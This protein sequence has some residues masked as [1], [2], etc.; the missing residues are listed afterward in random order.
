MGF[1]AAMNDTFSIGEAAKRLGKAV[2]TLQRWDRDGVLKAIKTPT[3]RRVYTLQMLRASMGLADEQQC[4]TAIAYCRV[5]SQ[6]QRPDLKNQRRVVEDF[7]VTKGLANVEFLEEVGGGLNFKRPIFLR[8]IDR[9]VAGE[10]SQLILAHKD[11]LARFGFDLLAHLC[12]THKCELLVIDSQQ[13]SPE[14]EMTQ[15]LMTIVHCFSSRLYGLRNCR[16]A[17]KEAL[18]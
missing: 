15:D 10:V 17:L 11:R 2:K 6:A 14:V 13:L 8:L 5:S 16:K 18:K 1:D 3:G 7:C 4:R 9:I 12:R